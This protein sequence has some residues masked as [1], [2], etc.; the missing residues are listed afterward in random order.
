[1]RVDQSDQPGVDGQP[2]NETGFKIE[3]CTGNVVP[4]LPRL[5]A[6]QETFTYNNTGLSRSTRYR[7]RVRAFNGGNS[8]YSNI[9]TVRTL[10]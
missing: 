2:N 9:I 7:Y 4:A 1:M 6:G 3:R 10:R 5:R 8:G